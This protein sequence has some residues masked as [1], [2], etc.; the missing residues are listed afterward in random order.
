MS[1]TAEKNIAIQKLFKDLDTQTDIL[2]LNCQHIVSEYIYKHYELKDLYNKYKHMYRLFQKSITH[3]SLHLNKLTGFLKTV[4]ARNVLEGTAEKLVEQDNIMREFMSLVEGDKEIETRLK[5]IEERLLQDGTKL[6]NVMKNNEFQGE[7]QG[8][9][10]TKMTSD[11]YK[12]NSTITHQE[13]LDLTENDEEKKNLEDMGIL[14]LRKEVTGT[15]D[16]KSHYYVWK[17]N[18]DELKIG[19]DQTWVLWKIVDSDQDLDKYQIK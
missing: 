7:T 4:D 9:M 6:M 10:A 19:E 18:E 15:P 16:A 13:V 17:K 1:G 11:E 8:R 5:T 2:T 3:T 12:E 14:I